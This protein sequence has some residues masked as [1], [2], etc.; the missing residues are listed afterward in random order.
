M[1]VRVC[2]CVVLWLPFRACVRLHSRVFVRDGVPVSVCVCVCVA[3]F[4]R[5]CWCAC[6]RVCVCV[7]PG[8]LQLFKLRHAFM[9][10]SAGAVTESV[11][12]E[13]GEMGDGLTPEARRHVEALLGHAII[14]LENYRKMESKLTQYRMVVSMGGGEHRVRSSLSLQCVVA[15]VF[16]CE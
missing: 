7:L 9:V 13:E 5:M 15:V 16:V 11:G 4:L 10:A 6:A 1:C 3:A 8:G 2:V 12:A 14:L